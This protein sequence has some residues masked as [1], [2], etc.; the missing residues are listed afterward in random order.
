MNFLK[1]WFY[2][3]KELLVGRIVYEVGRQ[4]VWIMLS[5]L[6]VHELE[7]IIEKAKENRE[8][9]GH[10]NYGN[11]AELYIQIMRERIK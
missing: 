1:K 3:Q 8:K 7:K 6:G 2:N 4:L 9:E 11:L 5:D 10:H